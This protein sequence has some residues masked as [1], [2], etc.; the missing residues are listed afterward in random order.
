MKLWIQNQYGELA[1][2]RSMTGWGSGFS[3]VQFTTGDRILASGA[4]PGDSIH[5]YLPDLSSS[6]LIPNEPGTGDFSSAALSPDQKRIGTITTNGYFSSW[7]ARY[8]TLE[9]RW[10][11]DPEAGVLAWNP[12][13]PTIIAIGSPGGVRIWD[14][15]KDQDPIVDLPVG[16]VRCMAWC[17]DG[18]LLAIGMPSRIEI[19]NPETPRLLSSANTWKLLYSIEW[20]PDSKMLASL[21][22]FD[23]WWGLA[24]ESGEY[25]CTAFSAAAALEIWDTTNL[26]GG[27]NLSRVDSKSA[28]RHYDSG[29]NCIAWAPNSTMIA[30]ATGMPGCFMGNRIGPQCGLMEPGVMLYEANQTTGLTSIRNMT[31]PMRFVS[32]IDWSGDGSKIVAGSMDGTI[33]IWMVGPGS[34][35]KEIGNPTLYLGG[36]VVTVILIDILRRRTE[37]S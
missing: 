19:W 3:W 22:G 32:S 30:L 23:P 28:V 31:G 11:T 10:P 14:L 2:A 21:A 24:P 27:G 12:A 20:S 18:S 5:A 37:P 25:P 13:D 26:R 1:L 33:W 35:P 34:L 29:P 6:I 7:D 36:L 8:G 4:A 16:E 15:E 17:P 9:T